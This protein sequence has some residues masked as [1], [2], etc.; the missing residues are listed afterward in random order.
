HTPLPVFS[1]PGF[2]T[3]S[4]RIPSTPSSSATPDTTSEIIDLS[5][6]S[7]QP[8]RKRTSDVS[9]CLSDVPDA[10]KRTRFDPSNEK[11]NLSVIPSI[12]Q[13]KG[14]EKEEHKMDTEEKPWM[15]V[16]PLGDPNPFGRL[17]EDFP[18]VVEQETLKKHKDLLELSLEILEGY[19]AWNQ[20]QLSTYE[21]LITDYARSPNPKV[22]IESMQ[23]VRLIFQERITAI[24]GVMSSRGPVVQASEPIISPYFTLPSSSE[25]IQMSD[26]PDVTLI[27]DEIEDAQLDDAP[28]SDDMYWGAVEDID[29]DGF[30]ESFEAEQTFEEVEEIPSHVQFASSP[31]YDEVMKTLRNIFRLE[32]FRKNQLE[33]I[34]ATLEGR[35]A[36]VLMPTGGGKSLCYQLPAVCQGGR[37]KGITIVI[38]PLKSL[39]SNQLVSLRQ[40]NI[41]VIAWN[42]ESTDVGYIVQRLRGN[43]KPS[44]LYVSPEKLKESGQLRSIMHNLHHEEKIAR[45]VIDE[46]HCIST[47]GQDFREA[48]SCL[49]DLRYEFPGV[50]MMALTATATTATLADIKK[51]LKLNQ[52]LAYLTQSFNRPNLNY[53]IHDKGKNILDNIVDFIF[54]KH[55]DHTG[56]I[57]CLGREKCEKVAQQLRS[58]GLTARHYH[59]RLDPADKEEVLDQW[60]HDRCK[61]IVATIAFGMGID[62]PDVR[63]VIHHDLPKSLD[64][65]YQETGRA[66]RDGKPADCIL[67][68]TYRDFKAIVKM[69]HNDDTTPESR[70]R[71][72]N[73]ARLVVAY[74]L[75]KSDCRR[76]QL[77][78]FFN[79]N[80]DDRLCQRR[81]DN[82][83]KD[84]PVQEEDLTEE[85]Q[86]IVRLMQSFGSDHISL[87]HCRAVY[88]GANTDAVR[89]K[90]H[91]QLKL[92]GAGKHL[93]N[94]LMEQ[95]FK[96]LCLLKITDE[97]ARPMGPKNFHVYY[98]TLGN[99]AD[100]LLNGKMRVMLRHRPRQP[101]VVASASTGQPR[102]PKQSKKKF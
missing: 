3:V 39:M 59:A 40:K 68:Y 22:D 19:L 5:S 26:Q 86:E 42:S 79:E 17:E 100:D 84:G 34:L 82:C 46:A 63:F 99:K 69:I 97:M 67:Y 55:R 16:A 18:W 64:G 8:S 24:R 89:K 70:T 52:N 48:Y 15:N 92:F 13:R 75:N 58:K 36:L 73:A 35:D 45:F 12:S 33:A 54:L 88:K 49:G 62:K 61:I 7:P 29:M 47:W 2:G 1:T 44:L 93:A 60:Q 96:H 57:Y 90:R 56:I 37:S 32:N 66:G 10:I 78:Q 101:K 72:E 85:A 65:Y 14:K 38:S 41:D 23:G 81:C 25:Q 95:L 27:D 31:Y 98:F 91:D 30:D 74:A 76:V 83:T 21:A 51:Q 4:R 6:D 77:L 9:D 102:K 11:E 50:P 87:E 28:A 43:P 20:G 53:I 80:F 71:Q 94:D